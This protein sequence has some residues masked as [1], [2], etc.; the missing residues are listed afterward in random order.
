MFSVR[1]AFCLAVI[2]LM[3]QSTPSS[4][5]PVNHFGF[6]FQGIGAFQT[7]PGPENPI[8][9]PG[10]VR[11]LVCRGLLGGSVELTWDNDPFADPT[12]QIKIFGSNDR[13]LSGHGLFLNRTQGSATSIII[14]KRDD[15]FFS[16]SAF[17]TFSVRNSSGISALCT[18]LL[19]DEIKINRP[20]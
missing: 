11:N 1:R 19:G 4:A 5:T 20:G 15:H 13:P 16:G 10:P 18:F 2:L 6:V 7:A 17:I 14:Q 8:P 12:G 3:A 9:E